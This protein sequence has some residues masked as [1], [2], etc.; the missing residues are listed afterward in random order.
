M[1]REK[2]TTSVMAANIPPID[3]SSVVL[4]KSGISDELRI[5]R[6]IKKITTRHPDVIFF[7]EEDQAIFP[8]IVDRLSQ[9]YR[10]YYPQGFNRSWYAAVVVAVRRTANCQ[11]TSDGTGI[12]SK[13][14]KWRILDVNGI[15]MLGVH[16]PQPN[17]PTYADFSKKVVAVAEEGNT[18]LIIGDFN[19]RRGESIH[20]PNFQ[21]ILPDRSTS[22]FGNQLDYI[23]VRNGRA[24]QN[25]RIDDGC[26]TP[27]EELF[28]DHA[29]IE[30]D[31]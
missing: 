10:F 30:V 7:L 19:P 13:S 24:F 26:M 28:S 15:T 1:T 2:D 11:K 9:K 25:E 21:S 6:I 27:R 16:F 29:I 18:D 14:G 4:K 22:L 5:E 23:F 8:R 12:V 3:R 17:D 20:L 31:L